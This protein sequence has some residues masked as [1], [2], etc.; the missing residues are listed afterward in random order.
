MMWNKARTAFWL[1]IVVHAGAYAQVPVRP[2]KWE[3]TGAYKG[4]P[5]GGDA[6]RVRTVCLSAQAL[7]PVPEK[8]LIEASPPPTDDASKPSPK[9]DYSPVRRDGAKSSWGI[10]CTNPTMTGTGSATISSPEQV[11]LSEALELKMGFA[12]RSIQ[13]TVRARRVGDCS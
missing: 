1:A 9:C 8:A 4:L 10:T 13:H 5:F 7:E 6:E 11:E 12:A 2:G 3:L